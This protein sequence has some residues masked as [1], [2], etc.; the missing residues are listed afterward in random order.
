MNYMS[1]I[2]P[3]M[4]GTLH[5]DRN[6]PTDTPPTVD[7]A[8]ALSGVP[9]ACACLVGGERWSSARAC[10]AVPLR[11]RTL[12]EVVVASVVVFAR[13]HPWAGM[14]NLSWDPRG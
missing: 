2:T 14:G 6:G 10:L 11:F 7:C 8:P 12:A 3:I 13:L 9:R 4:M 1:M 5:T